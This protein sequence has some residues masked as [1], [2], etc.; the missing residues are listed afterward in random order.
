MSILSELV[1]TQQHRLIDLLPTAGVG[2]GNWANF[3]G[4]KLRAASNPKYCYE[5]SFVEPEKV[6][7]LN[8]WHSQITEDHDGV[9]F[10]ALNQR[11]RASKLQGVV[12]ARGLRMDE[13]IQTAFKGNLPVRVIIVA[14]RRRDINNPEDRASHVSKRLLDPIGW[15]V[16]AYDSKTGQCTL[17]RSNHHRFI[18]QFSIQQASQE[19]GNQKPERREVSGSRFDRSPE[20]R[21]RVLKRANGKCEWCEQP[22]FPTADG[23]V[24]LETHHVTPLSEDG[25]DVVSNV[26]ALCPNHHREAHYG[27]DKKGMMGKLK[28][29]VEKIFKP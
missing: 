6:V 9:P 26:V 13:A 29:K 5:W 2:I 23:G 21:E 1:P 10:V 8:L 22:G 11:E 20:V 15:T 7:V 25:P 17:R 16:A 18:D 27:K 12:R 19:V 28:E 3:K 14:G 4:G 24:Y